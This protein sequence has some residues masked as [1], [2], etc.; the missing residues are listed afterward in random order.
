[1]I[2]KGF[3]I[4]ALALPGIASSQTYRWTDDQGVVRY[5]ATPPP[6][7][8]RN[9]QT[10]PAATPPPA[11]QP[12]YELSRL[13]AE[14]PVTLYTTSSC[15]EACDAA[16]DAL[17]LRG[18][19]FRETA[20]SSLEV[21]EEL[22]RVAGA[23]EVPTVVVGRE[24]HRGFEAGA[25]NA[26]LDRAGYPRTGIL[27]AGTRKGPD[28]DPASAGA[29]AA[30]PQPSKPAAPR[31]PYDPSGLVGP[32]PKRGIYDPSGLVGPAPKPGPYDPEKQLK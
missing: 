27:P 19:P 26:M 6:K 30:Q 11:P 3:L 9:V 1:M 5:T 22:K 31:G 2:H 15:G 20:V 16:R 18:V 13:Q 10:L 7:S 29:A 28:A 32:A 21:H 23:V 17:N 12:S 24:A 14:Y 4:L 8:A 25:V